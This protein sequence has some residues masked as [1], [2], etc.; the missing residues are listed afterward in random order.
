MSL[1]VPISVYGVI[2]FIMIFTYFCVGIV[3]ADDSYIDEYDDMYGKDYLSFDNWLRMHKDAVYKIGW[4]GENWN[5]LVN[6]NPD[7]QRRVIEIMTGYG[8]DVDLDKTL[9]PFYVP[10]YPIGWHF[11]NTDAKIW[12]DN[13]YKWTEHVPPADHINI[14]KELTEKYNIYLS[15]SGFYIEYT[16][17]EQLHVVNKNIID[18]TI[19]FLGALPEGFGKMMDL[20]TFNIPRISVELKAVLVIFFAPMWFILIIGIAPTVAKFIRSMASVVSAVLPW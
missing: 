15:G 5:D 7:L 10:E 11:Y 17:T 1:H 16:D 18:T 14:Q 6:E 2:A 9:T 20:L 19:E 3:Y 4:G 12:Y 8:Y 13:L